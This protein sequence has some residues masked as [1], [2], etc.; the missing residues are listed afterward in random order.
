MKKL[1]RFIF[2]LVLF[3]L[4]AFI[5]TIAQETSDP[6]KSY[7]KSLMSLGITLGTGVSLENDL[8]DGQAYWHYNVSAIPIPIARVEFRTPLKIGDVT[9]VTLDFILALLILR[10]MVVRR[11][12]QVI[13][14]VNSLV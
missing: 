1:L 2:P 14:M 8:N 3:M 11:S 5:K 7:Y 12:C 10:L 13:L 9:I 6:D 4:S